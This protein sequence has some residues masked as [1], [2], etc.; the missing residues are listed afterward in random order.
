MSK[1]T[2]EEKKLIEYWLPKPPNDA[3][4]AEKRFFDAA[5]KKI[6]IKRN[7]QGLIEFSYQALSET[8]KFT[9]GITATK[10]WPFFRPKQIKKGE[11]EI[12][13]KDALVTEFGQKYSIDV[14]NAKLGR[15]KGAVKA[16]DSSKKS[17]D[18]LTRKILARDKSLGSTLL[19][20]GQ[21]NKEIASELGVHVSTVRRR[22]NKI[23]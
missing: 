2:E 3:T 11:E 12:R 4:P 17:A 6:T 5:V 9:L 19:T 1:W 16:R 15:S 10:E 23:N 20:R 18:E 13:R 7:Q 8:E 21:K 14:L 22:F